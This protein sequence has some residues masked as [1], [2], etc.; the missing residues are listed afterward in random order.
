MRAWKIVAFPGAAMRPP[1]APSEPHY[2]TRFWGYCQ[3]R[4]IYHDDLLDTDATNKNRMAFRAASSSLQPIGLL[5][6]VSDWN[7]C[8]PFQGLIPSAISIADLNKFR[9]KRGLRLM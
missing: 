3:G 4:E 1:R 2:P 6:Y 5:S 7:C 8:H 9:F